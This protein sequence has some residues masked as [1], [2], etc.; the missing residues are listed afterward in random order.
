MSTTTIDELVTLLG[1]KLD[2]NAKQTLQ[3]F[4]QS[5]VSVAKSVAVAGAAVVGAATAFVLFAERSAQAGSEIE[6][7]HKLTGLSTD[8]IQRWMYASQMIGGDAKGILG[9]LDAMNKALHPVLPQYVNQALI[10]A[11]GPRLAQIEDVKELFLTLSDM[12]HGM[13]KPQ[14]EQW[15]EPMGFSNAGVQ[16]I[17]RSRKEIEGFFNSAPTLSAKQTAAADKM[18]QQWDKFKRS[19]DIFMEGVA[20]KFFPLVERI[21]NFLM[22]WYN[23]NRR[24]IDQGVDTVVTSLAKAFTSLAD[25]LVK[26]GFLEDFQKFLKFLS[27]PV[28]LKNGAEKMI[29]ALAFAVGILGA[30]FTLIAMAVS[31]I[32]AA[33]HDLTTLFS[34]MTAPL[35]YVKDFLGKHPEIVKS[36]PLLGIFLGS[37]LKQDSAHTAT[38]EEELYIPKLFDMAGDI[39]T[40]SKNATAPVA[41]YKGSSVQYNDHR[42]QTVKVEVQ[43]KSEAPPE[44]TGEAI[45]VGSSRGFEQMGNVMWNTVAPGGR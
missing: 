6:R 22:Q 9:D 45:A 43:H 29:L 31:L 13:P 27:D 12:V 1:F 10:Q 42:H 19:L 20:M 44:K 33:A 26:G 14:G 32:V 37:L 15:L 16:L 17:L 21:L 4:E 25:V 30:K 2:P 23:A 40:A 28:L 38:K 8:S 39:L 36:H 5:V 7:F 41:P 24:L 11:L 35:D 34:R 18:R 3:K